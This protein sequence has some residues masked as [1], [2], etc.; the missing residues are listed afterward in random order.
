MPTLPDPFDEF[1]RQLAPLMESR[2]C[3]SDPQSPP[4]FESIHFVCIA[5]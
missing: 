4:L 5:A 3:P 1:L 2:K